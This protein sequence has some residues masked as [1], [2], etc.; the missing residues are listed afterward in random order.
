MKLYVSASVIQTTTLRNQLLVKKKKKKKKKEQVWYFTIT[1]AI[2][3]YLLDSRTSSSFW[4][5]VSFSNE[6]NFSSS[7]E[8]PRF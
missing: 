1:S 6:T 7:L 4:F 3:R 2:H 5:L 8:L